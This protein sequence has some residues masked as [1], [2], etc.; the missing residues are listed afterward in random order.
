MVSYQG[1]IWPLLDCV[2][3]GPRYVSNLASPI[4]GLWHIIGPHPYG[5]PALGPC[6]NTSLQYILQDPNTNSPQSFLASGKAS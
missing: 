4:G 3:H 5:F 6:W 2:T 1:F